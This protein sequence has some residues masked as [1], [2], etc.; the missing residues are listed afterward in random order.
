MPYVRSYERSRSNPSR[1]STF[2]TSSLSTGVANSNVGGVLE[3][4]DFGQFASRSLEVPGAC[5]RGATLTSK[6]V[7]AVALGFLIAMVILL[8]EV[9]T[10]PREIE[11]VVGGGGKKDAIGVVIG[12]WSPI[13]GPRCFPHLGTRIRK[14]FIELLASLAGLLGLR[15]RHAPGA[16]DEA[17]PVRSK[18]MFAA[19]FRSVSLTKLLDN[20]VLIDAA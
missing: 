3:E 16:G 15:D 1:R 17:A 14:S 18:P 7:P 11:R 9:A 2:L 13:L 12:C 8:A 19:P 10:S 5:S 6:G 4:W 20:S